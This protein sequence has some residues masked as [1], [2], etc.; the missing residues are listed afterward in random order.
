MMTKRW[1]RES[2]KTSKRS[3][4]LEAVQSVN[5]IQRQR[6]MRKIAPC[7]RQCHLRQ[8]LPN[9]LSQHR[10]LLPTQ[11]MTTRPTLASKTLLP[12][13]NGQDQLEVR[14]RKRQI[15]QE[16]NHHRLA[17]LTSRLRF[18]LCRS[19]MQRRQTISQRPP[20]VRQLRLLMMT[21]LRMMSYNK[22]TNHELR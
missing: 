22:P 6:Q 8:R 7:P 14:R 19:D 15:V 4:K 9:Q 18:G 16:T 12:C 5:Q 20:R 10:S 21:R 17:N 1:K 11:H 13:H 2:L 3:P